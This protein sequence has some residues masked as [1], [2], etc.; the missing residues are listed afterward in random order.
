MTSRELPTARSGIYILHQT[1][2]SE[3]A[4]N[5]DALLTVSDLLN[6]RHLQEALSTSVYKEATAA[7]RAALEA[8]P[9]L[10]LDDEDGPLAEK[11]L[12]TLFLWHLAFLEVPQPMSLTDLV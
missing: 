4:L 12:K 6:S 2:N 1:L 5:R 10:D 11:L 9:S 8:L 7:Y 3:D